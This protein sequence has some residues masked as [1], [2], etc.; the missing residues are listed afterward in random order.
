M[1]A[2]FAALSVVFALGAIPPYIMSTV[3][4]QTRPERATWAI[5]SV[6][7]AVAFV[8]QMLLGARWSLVFAGMDMLG[9]LTVFGLSIWRGV[10]G[11][12]PLDR[13]AFAMAVVGVAISLAVKAPFIA[14][15]GVMLADISGTVPTVVKTFREPQSEFGVSWLLTGTS[16][17][18]GAFA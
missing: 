11:W 17:L 16:A 5:F 15:L 10:G 9:S 13:L 4:G 6:I 2:L 12:T 8:S 3:R 1:L 14:L 18:F 7:N